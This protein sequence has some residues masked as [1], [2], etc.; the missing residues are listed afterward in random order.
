MLAV[1]SYK[2]E[3]VKEC[4]QKVDR[5]LAAYRNLV[6]FSSGIREQYRVERSNVRAP[7]RRV[8]DEIEKKYP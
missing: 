1:T 6:H 4:R 7:R 3:Y 5:Q 8:F 2:H